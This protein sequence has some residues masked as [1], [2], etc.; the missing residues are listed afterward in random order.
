M[1]LFAEDAWLIKAWQRTVRHVSI[2]MFEPQNRNFQM[3]FMSLLLTPTSTHKRAEQLNCQRPVE[4]GKRSS[5]VHFLSKE[6]LKK[7][8]TL[9]TENLCSPLT[10]KFTLE[11]NK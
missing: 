8:A 9:E 4:L 11:A 1:V 6:H 10:Y 5:I 2:M 3:G 7:C